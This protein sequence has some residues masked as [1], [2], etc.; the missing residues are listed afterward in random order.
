MISGE[1]SAMTRGAQ[2]MPHWSA[3]SWDMLILQ[4]SAN[5]RCTWVF[6][7][8]IR[9]VNSVLRLPVS[10]LILIMSNIILL[11]VENFSLIPR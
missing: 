8:K 7:Q 11:S 10:L 9:Q 5:P 2:Q 4:V 1:L 3:S 6:P